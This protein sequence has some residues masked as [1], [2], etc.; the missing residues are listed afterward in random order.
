MSYSEQNGQVTLTMSR[1][2]WERIIFAL[3]AVTGYAVK[4]GESI[5]PHLELMNRLNQGNPNYT[6]YQVRPP[7]PGNPGRT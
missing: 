1:D 4:N 3:G 6:P 2:D 7:E 5:V